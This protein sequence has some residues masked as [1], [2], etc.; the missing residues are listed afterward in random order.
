MLKHNHEEMLESTGKSRS[1]MNLSFINVL[2]KNGEMLS[3][4]RQHKVKNDKRHRQL[5][6]ELP[7]IVPDLKVRTSAPSEQTEK[8]VTSFTIAIQKI[9]QRSI[10]R[11]FGFREGACLIQSEKQLLL[12][13]GFAGEFDNNRPH[14]HSFD[15]NKRQW[16]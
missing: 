13:G 7:V 14:L 16:S 15:L 2:K 3:K 12:Y 10:S 9:D 6:I 5:D 11:F 8:A 1:L 4:R